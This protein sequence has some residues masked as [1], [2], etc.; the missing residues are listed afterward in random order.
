MLSEKQKTWKTAFEEFM[1]HCR[2]VQNKKRDPYPDNVLRKFARFM[3][4][5]VTGSLDVR[6]VKRCVSSVSAHA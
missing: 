4:S 5:T 6:I 2:T 3:G 1:K